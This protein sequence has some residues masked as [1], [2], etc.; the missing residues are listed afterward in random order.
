PAAAALAAR[1]PAPASR[2]LRC[3]HEL[4]PAAQVPAAGGRPPPRLGRLADFHPGA[5]GE[6]VHD[7][8]LHRLDLRI[9]G[10]ALDHAPRVG[11]AGLPARADAGRREVDVLQIVLAVERRRE[12]AHNVHRRA[13]TPRCELFAGRAFALGSGQMLGELADH[14]PQ[15][16]DLLLPSN[17]AVRAARILDVLLA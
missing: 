15:M 12:Q 10:R 11:E 9:P 14:M 4:Q 13:A 3:L 5:R 7:Y 6:L 1:T 2:D 16:V 8:A 17:V